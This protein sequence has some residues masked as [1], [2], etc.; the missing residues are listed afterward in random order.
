MTN[1]SV[2]GRR[3]IPL[4]DPRRPRTAVVL[5]GGSDIAQ[6]IVARLADEGLERVVLAAR[7]PA[8]AVERLTARAPGVDAEGARWDALE[9]ESAVELLDGARRSLGAIE[10]VLCAVGALGHHAGISMGP[11]EVD[12]MVRTNFAGPA[13]ALAAAGQVLAEQGHGTI[14]VLSSVAGLRA[15]RSNYVYGSTKAG[16]DL[17][18][19]GLGDALAPSGAR[20]LVVR[21]GFVRS[22]M[23]EGLDPAPFST[24][25]DTVAEGV[26]AA[27]GGRR[28]ILSV[29]RLLGPL[30]V[31]LRAAPRPLWRRIAGDR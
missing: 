2:A 27:L 3:A 22:K 6:A 11:I 8:T 15:R 19:Q 20:V 1:D 28:E 10:L 26:V 16:L 13:A 31:G 4:P 23:T 29:P 12:E 5:G 30:F 9:P 21:P 7:D 18:A 14:V 24:D 25:P 17:F